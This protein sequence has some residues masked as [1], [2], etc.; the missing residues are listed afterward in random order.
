MKKVIAGIGLAATALSAAGVAAASSSNAAT[1]QM[2]AHG[3]A[4]MASFPSWNTCQ[5]HADW[6]VKN[7]TSHG[8][9]LVSGDV[10]RAK[11][12][13]VL[14][15]RWTYLTVYK[16]TK[17]LNTG[18]L[19]KESAIATP[20]DWFWSYEHDESGLATV[21]TQAKCQQAMNSFTSRVVAAKNLRLLPGSSCFT[22]GHVQRHFS[23][24]YLGT[25]GSVGLK[26]DYNDG[27]WQ[28]DNILSESSM[29]GYT[30]F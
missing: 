9:K 15:G 29:L 14:D 17:P 16:A 5:T 11:C 3:T 26:G 8:G 27:R 30:G 7:V 13:P 22:G 10:A 12:F 25:S 23:A 6:S 4:H 20:G 1:T 24:A 2:Y 18:D 19:T 28:H 21:F